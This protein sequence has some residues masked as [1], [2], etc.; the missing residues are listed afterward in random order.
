MTFRN[1]HSDTDWYS[2]HGICVYCYIVNTDDVVV[3][4]IVIDIDIDIDID[5][6]KNG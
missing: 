3:I 4:V 2:F 6:N 5:I 1:F